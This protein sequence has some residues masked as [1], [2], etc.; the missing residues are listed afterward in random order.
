MNFSEVFLCVN[1]TLYLAYIQ[2]LSI[3]KNTLICIAVQG[4]SIFSE[5]IWAAE[6]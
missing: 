4:T 2:S 1:K 6:N 5:V 3:K